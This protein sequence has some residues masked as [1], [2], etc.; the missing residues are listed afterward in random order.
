MS[1]E[2]V[3]EITEG[4]KHSSSVMAHQIY[5]ALIKDEQA[6]YLVYLKL[7]TKFG[8]GQKILS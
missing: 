2:E 6:A 5:D 3:K 1:S 4:D 7:A 8:A